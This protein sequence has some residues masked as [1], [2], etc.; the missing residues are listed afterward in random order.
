M[1]LKLCREG[2]KSVREGRW[3][4]GII[5]VIIAEMR[6]VCVGEGKRKEV[7]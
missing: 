4:V 1:E 2:W 7:C 6:R 5:L 3:W